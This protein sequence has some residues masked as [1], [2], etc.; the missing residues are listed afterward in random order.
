[1]LSNF[2]KLSFPFES[3]QARTFP[4]HEEKLNDLRAKHNTTHSFFR[5]EDKIYS[6]WAEGDDLK[7]GEECEILS[8]EITIIERAAKH[9]FYRTF[10]RKLEE[11][12]PENFYPLRPSDGAKRWGQS[13]KS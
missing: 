8:K 1:M 10:L 5:I 11:R 4:Y 13:K 6:I 2:C 9:L 3:F 7:E 12:V